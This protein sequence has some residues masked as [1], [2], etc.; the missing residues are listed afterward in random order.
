MFSKIRSLKKSYVP[1]R[2]LRSHTYTGTRA[3]IPQELT[4]SSSQALNPFP[5]VSFWDSARL[6]PENAP[7]E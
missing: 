2:L 6:E 4:S 3:H 7:S 1:P 5:Q